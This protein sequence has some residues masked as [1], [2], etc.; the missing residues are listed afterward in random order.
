MGTFTFGTGHQLMNALISKISSK[1]N[2]DG[3][4]GKV[5]LREGFTILD[6]LSGKD[7]SVLLRIE[8]GRDIE[9][10]LFDTTEDHWIMVSPVQSDA[11]E[12][13]I[14]NMFRAVRVV[15]FSLN[16]FDEAAACAVNWLAGNP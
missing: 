12:L 10:G 1:I 9:L 4:D 7:R 11:G 8:R 15:Q 13:Q 6:E 3:F 16:Q 2:S 5:E 14:P